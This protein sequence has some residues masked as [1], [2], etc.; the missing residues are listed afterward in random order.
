METRVLS[1][2]VIDGPSPP[3]D[4]YAYVRHGSGTSR[5]SAAESGAGRAVG[6]GF[7]AVRHLGETAHRGVTFHRPGAEVH[8]GDASQPP[9]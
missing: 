3:N 9:L 7:D 4:T 6:I 5:A 8:S 2:V 1:E